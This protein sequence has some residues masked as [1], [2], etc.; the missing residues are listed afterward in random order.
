MESSGSTVTGTSSTCKQ[1]H[2]KRQNKNEVAQSIT[3]KAFL[4]E[5]VITKQVIVAMVTY[6]SIS[7][8]FL[9]LDPSSAH[10]AT[11]DDIILKQYGKNRDPETVLRAFVL[12]K[13]FN[14]VKYLKSEGSEAIVTKMESG[15]STR[16]EKLPKRQKA[17]EG[18][19]DIVSKLPK[20]FISHILSFLPT[21]DAVRTSVLSKK[22]IYRWTSITN[23]DLD[24]SVFYSPKRKTGGKQCFV[25]FVYRALLL[26]K[27]SSVES[28]SLVITNKYDA[29][30]VNTWISSILNRSVKILHVESHFVLR[31]NAYTSH[32][33][34]N[35]ELSGIVFTLESSISSEDVTLSLPI[36]KVF[37]TINCTWLNAKGVT[38]KAPLLESIFI[39][40]DPESIPYELH[41]W[42]IKISALRL[43]EFT[44]YSYD[45]ISQR[46]VLLDPS[47]AHNASA[48][49]ILNR[50][51]KNRVS[52]TG[53]LVAQLLK[54]LSEVKF[55]KFVVS[56]VLALLQLNDAILPVFG[57][58]SH[59]ELGLVTA[60]VLLALLLRSPILK[61]LVFE[62][63]N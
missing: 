23:L 38:L 31:F 61:T 37:E 4:L 45:Y 54:Q 36:L 20:S 28:F 53:F 11:L 42:P 32:S 52:E 46:V 58:L 19:E 10:N 15:S 25:N 33:L 62:V 40:Q 7:S 13:Q 14:Q 51:E 5:S 18:G 9:L 43:T 8:Y 22:W 59:L 27:S 35:S 50:C 17:K 39:E 6:Q 56:E 1:K 57:M 26:T 24:D 48:N 3:L 44:F 2:L 21:K 60:E 55:L 16:K 41:Y 30:L 63:G 29:S 47:S 34:F 49:I 12:L